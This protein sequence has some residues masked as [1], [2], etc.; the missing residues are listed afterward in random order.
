MNNRKDRKKTNMIW[1]ALPFFGLFFG[2]LGPAIGGIIAYLLLNKQDNDFA[3]KVL[4]IGI[5]L[6]LFMLIAN[7]AIG[8]TVSSWISK[9]S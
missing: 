3:K 8:H 7:I 5:G 4:Y 9:M 6:S 1:S 2:L